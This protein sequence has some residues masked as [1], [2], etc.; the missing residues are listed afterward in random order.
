[1][2]SGVVLGNSFSIT[3]SGETAP[4]DAPT[5]FIDSNQKAYQI[6][7][8][9][10][11]GSGEQRLPVY[12]TKDND[13]KKEHRAFDQI[14]AIAVN[15]YGDTVVGAHVRW[16][17]LFGQKDGLLKMEPLPCCFS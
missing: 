16:T 4:G 15:Q 17:P 8:S 13:I 6:V 3:T 1:V 14:V 5:D 10:I 9:T 12:Y 7:K 11:M 2:L